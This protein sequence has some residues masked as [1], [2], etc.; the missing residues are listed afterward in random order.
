MPNEDG[1]TETCRISAESSH[2]L[3][4]K[5]YAV[6]RLSVRIL[7]VL[8]TFVILW[9]SLDVAWVIWQRMNA[10]PFYVLN[11]GDMLHTFGAFIAV[12][13][14]V[15]IF[16]NIVMYLEHNVI[17]VKLVL[18]T[19]LMAASRKVIVLDFQDLNPAYIWATGGVILAL[20]LT[21][22]LVTVKPG[23]RVGSG[24]ETRFTTPASRE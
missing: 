5:C 16:H 15:E 19:A 13:I 21:Y 10:N 2:A 8:M 4:G 3:L 20:G 12:L 18:A 11:I 6:I 17:Q 14:A 24:V 7:A 23:G 22:W 1:D 9:G